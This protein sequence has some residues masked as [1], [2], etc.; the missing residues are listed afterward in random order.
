MT[1][2][3]H[4]RVAVKERDRRWLIPTSKRIKLEDPVTPVYWIALK[5]R[6]VC[7]EAITDYKHLGEV[8]PS[9]NTDARNALL[10]ST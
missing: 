3:V 8:R 4:Q 10:Y 1:N 2:I 6:E 9:P 7:R 5:F